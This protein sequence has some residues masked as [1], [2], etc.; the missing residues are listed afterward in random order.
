MNTF[1]LLNRSLFF[2]LRNS[3]C[4]CLASAVTLMEFRNS[5]SPKC[6]SMYIE[7]SLN[8]C[9]AHCTWRWTSYFRPTNKLPSPNRKPSRLVAFLRTGSYQRFATLLQQSFTFSEWIIFA[10]NN[11]GIHRT[12]WA[13]ISIFITICI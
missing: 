4:P 8:V 3:I 10:N 9:I 5:G 2:E 1:M 6:T 12:Q 13:I 7:P 11:K